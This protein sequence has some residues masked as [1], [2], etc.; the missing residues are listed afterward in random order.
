MYGYQS[1]G[2]VLFPVSAILVVALGIVRLMSTS[3][4]IVQSLAA[5]AVAF[6]I[7][8]STMAIIMNSPE[9]SFLRIVYIVLTL[10]SLVA[11]MSFIRIGFVSIFIQ[12][13]LSAFAAAFITLT[14][15]GAR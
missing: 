7:N 10:L 11:F 5:L 15:F 4:S 6:A 2:N 9:V 3:S 8:L 13:L 14:Y 1:F 12:G